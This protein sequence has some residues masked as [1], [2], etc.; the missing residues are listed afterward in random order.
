VDTGKAAFRVSQLL[1]QMLYP[2]KSWLDIETPPPEK[3][4]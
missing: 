4:C 1:Q 2:L 3:L